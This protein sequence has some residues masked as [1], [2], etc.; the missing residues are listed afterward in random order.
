MR[1]R[2]TPVHSPNAS[3]AVKMQDAVLAAS[4]AAQH[5]AALNG[6]TFREAPRRYIDAHVGSC[7]NAKHAG[8]WTATTETY[9]LP[10]LG[11]VPVSEVGATHVLAAIEPIWT[12]KAETASRLRGRIESSQDYAK[13]RASASVCFAILTA[14]H[15]GE[16]R[17]A[18]WREINLVAVLADMSE[19]RTSNDPAALPFPG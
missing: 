4:K 14:A 3:A 8:Q 13:A 12:T 7:R 16:A 11:E 19:V 17:G 10:F 1:K 15:S 18:C 9:A 5:D 2:R 6:I